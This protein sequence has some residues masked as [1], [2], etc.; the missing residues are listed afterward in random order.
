MGLVILI[1][2]SIGIFYYKD[3]SRLKSVKVDDSSK[4]AEIK[5]K[6]DKV[7]NDKIAALVS[8]IFILL[9]LSSFQQ[10]DSANNCIYL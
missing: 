3:E 1:L 9:I 5:L 2:V 10:Q 8:D 7:C 4:Y 6:D